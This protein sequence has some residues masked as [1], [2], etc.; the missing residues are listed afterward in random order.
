MA[1]YYFII[2]ILMVGLTGVFFGVQYR[3]YATVD[4]SFNKMVRR[5]ILAQARRV[6]EKAIEHVGWETGNPDTNIAFQLYSME[7]RRIAKEENI[8]AITII[9]RN[10]RVVLDPTEHLKRG[11]PY[12]G[13]FYKSGRLARPDLFLTPMIEEG[14]QSF[15]AASMPIAG[16]RWAVMEVSAATANAL[17]RLRSRFAAITAAGLVFLCCVAAG[18]VFLFRGLRKAE[19]LMLE[20]ERLSTIG[21]LSATVAHEIKNPLGIIRSSAQL[22]AD[23]RSLGENDKKALHYIIEESDRLDRKIKELLQLARE[24]MPRLAP[25]DMGGVVREI[26]GGY[27][28]AGGTAYR[29]TEEIPQSE[30]WIRADRDQVIQVL[31]NLLRNS[32]ES[33]PSG[34]E[35]NI[36][37][38]AKN[39]AGC[40]EITDSGPGIPPA[41]HPKVFEPFY[42]KKS[43]GTGLGL[44]L[45]KRIL[46]AHGGR[47]YAVPTEGGCRMAAEFPLEKSNG[48]DSRC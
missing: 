19:K 23:S 38:T 3:S 4:K 36:S 22:V 6:S 46:E 25:L 5:S 30:I 39:G 48:E 16:N 31:H 47:I 28:T 13:A 27:H 15:M 32:M 1:R 26:L 20:K 34:G 45:C 24:V 40:L 35:I 14:G 7:L 41:E 9:D 8:N 12:P 2:A 37:V 42:T 44:A 18:L 29:F 33:M 43:R 21:E 11:E 10:D 17:S